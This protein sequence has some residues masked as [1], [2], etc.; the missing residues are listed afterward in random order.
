MDNDIFKANKLLLHPDFEATIKD[1]NNINICFPKSNTNFEFFTDNSQPGGELIRSLGKIRKHKLDSKQGQIVYE[2]KLNT[3]AYDESI[4]T[5]N[6]LEGVAYITSH[7]LILLGKTQYIPQLYLTFYFYTKSSVI[8]KQL[9]YIKN[10]DD[11][12]LES[13]RDYMKDKIYFLLKNTPENSLLLI[14]GPLIGG[15]LYTYMIK[16]FEDFDKKNIIPI[17]FV[18]NSSSNLIT[19][20]V[21]EL[22][23]KYNSDLHWSY[24]YLQVGERTSFF[25]YTDKINSKNSKIFCYIK[26]YPGSP[27]RVEIHSGTYKKHQN[28]LDNIFNMI[29]FLLI[30]QG[31]PKNPQLRPIAIAEKYARNS[32]SLINIRN[33][34][35]E[36]GIIPTINQSRFG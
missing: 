16:A 4:F 26:A 32:L 34:I 20:N 18:K 19:G 33:I 7:A 13:K 9:L 30:A 15:D 21:K 24:E 31:N 2:S 14:D 23:N 17:F 28:I 10:T 27:Q 5:F 22:K 3:V 29:Y 25:Q 35:K 11:P 36:I 12:E 1:V 6:S 8:G